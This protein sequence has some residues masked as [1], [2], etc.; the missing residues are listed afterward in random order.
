MN[1]FRA[2]LLSVVIGACVTSAHRNAQVDLA[3]AVRDSLTDTPLVGAQVFLT[4]D[5]TVLHGPPRRWPRGVVTDSIGRFVFYSV[6]PGSYVLQARFIG[7]SARWLRVTVPQSGDGSV[8]LRLL[9]TTIRLGWWPPDSAQVARNRERLSDW[10][11]QNGDP[12][13]IEALRKGWIGNLSSREPADWDSLLVAAGLTRDSSEISRLA[14]H[15]TDP[16]ICRRAGQTYDQT[17]GATDIHF[18]V[19][20]VGPILIVVDGP[21]DATV[22]LDHDYR[23]LTMLV[24]P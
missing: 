14:R 13:A 19:V 18:L 21:G 12:D 5:T 10:T 1:R 6:V 23:V 8:M 16:E 22:L 3:G 24:A 9:P 11:C 20:E 7:F 15:V 17:V 4:E 2:I